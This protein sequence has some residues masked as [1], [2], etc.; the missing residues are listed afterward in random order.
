MDLWGCWPS[1]KIYFGF[2][3]SG[4][5]VMKFGQH[6]DEIAALYDLYD[7][8]HR[9]SLNQLNRTDRLWTPTLQY[10]L[11]PLLQ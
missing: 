1:R 11:Q 9:S 4:D 10:E 6:R 5:T 7:H 2:V 8:S 3:G